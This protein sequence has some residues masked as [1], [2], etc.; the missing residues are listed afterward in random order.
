MNNF[1]KIG[2]ALKYI[3]GHLDEKINLESLSEKFYFSPY[4]FHRLFTAVVGK[5]LAAYIRDRRILFAC[6][7]LGTTDNTVL[8]IT[9]NCGF[10]SAQAFSRTFSDLQG[11][12]PSEYRK[13][14]Y[15]PDIISAD[16]LVMRFTNRLRGGILLNPNIIKRDRLLVAGTCGDGSKT[17]D[18]WNAFEKLSAEK[19]L[20][21]TLSGHGY[22][23][24]MYEG[25]RCTVYAGNVVSDRKV[26][27]AYTLLELPPCRYASF[28]VYVSNGYESENNAMDEW[29]ASNEEGYSEKLLNGKNYCVEYY[30]ERFSGEESGSIVE[31]W[32]PIE[33]G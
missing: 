29:L 10:H 22:E 1:T 14:G 6:R 13:Q 30:D 31:I 7:Q 5:S 20:G 8:E 28:E 15:Q 17:W 3:D 32:I 25:E 12:S 16:E 4:Y 2:E 24:R 33:K 23:V 19:P 11:I 18:V 21:N 27:S 9:L 26:D